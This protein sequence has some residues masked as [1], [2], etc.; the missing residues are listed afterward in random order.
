MAYWEW[1]WLWHMRRE[2]AQMCWGATCA[3]TASLTG[4]ID[5][6][7]LDGEAT[8][9]GGDGNRA[10]NSKDEIAPC[11]PIAVFTGRRDDA[12]LDKRSRRCR[13][14]APPSIPSS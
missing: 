9:A 14:A 10:K 3:K 4:G 8:P 12:W 7:I 5:L 1:C 6:V 2:L 13:G 11:P